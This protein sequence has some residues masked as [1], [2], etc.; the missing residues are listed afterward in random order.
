MIELFTRRIDA[1]ILPESAALMPLP[2]DDDISSLSAILLNNEYYEFLLQ[3][4]VQ[5]DGITF[6]AARRHKYK[7]TWTLKNKE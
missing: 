7:A 5:I 1:I 6:H 3:G 4:R 2:I